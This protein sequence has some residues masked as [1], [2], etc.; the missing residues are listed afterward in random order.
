MDYIYNDQYAILFSSDDH[1]T[2]PQLNSDG[3]G[4]KIADDDWGLRYYAI[5]AIKVT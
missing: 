4:F 1:N 3:T 2:G 5:R